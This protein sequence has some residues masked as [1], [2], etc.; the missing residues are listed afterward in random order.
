MRDK[1]RRHRPLLHTR[2][3]PRRAA[4]T[5]YWLHL[6]A[7]G[8]TDALARRSPPLTAQ[9]CTRHVGEKPCGPVSYR[10]PTFRRPQ[11]ARSIPGT[12]VRAR[13]AVKAWFRCNAAAGDVAALSVAS[14]WFSVTP[15][16]VHR[17]LAANR[18]QTQCQR[19]Q[20]TSSRDLM[21]RAR[22]TTSC[23]LQAHPEPLSARSLR[24]LVD[25]RATLPPLLDHESAISAAQTFACSAMRGPEVK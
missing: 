2:E 5:R 20:L 23:P 15:E 1:P 10:W 3:N 25:R 19:R 11:R 6:F 16:S 21:A 7:R 24:I 4:A 18:F 12:G 22:S 17:A 13:P 9:E 14:N 8:R